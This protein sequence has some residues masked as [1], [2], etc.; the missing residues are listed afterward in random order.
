MKKKF[1][2]RFTLLHEAFEVE[3]FASDPEKLKLLARE[4]SESTGKEV[5]P[6]EMRSRL[7]G[8]STF[9]VQTNRGWSLGQMARVMMLLCLGSA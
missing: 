9:L 3:K 2:R 7:T 8:G 5:T 1:L 4:E 6:E